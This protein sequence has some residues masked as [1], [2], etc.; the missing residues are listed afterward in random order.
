[1]GKIL[2]LRGLTEAVTVKC[3]YDRKS[4]K[5]V[6]KSVDFFKSSLIHSTLNAIEFKQ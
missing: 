6:Y 4:Q 5:T 2:K 1:M 3:I